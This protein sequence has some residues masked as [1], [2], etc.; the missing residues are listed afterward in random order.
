V[1]FGLALIALL[2][3]GSGQ[4]AAQREGPRLDVSVNAVAAL[5]EGPLVTS[6]N[7]LA[8]ANTLDLLKNGLFPARIHY[9]I[10]LWKKGGWLG[11]DPA[12]RSE[13]DVIVRYDPSTRLYAAV[14]RFSDNSCEN[15][16]GYPT[17]VAAEEQ[18][19]KP[20]RPPLHPSRAGRYYYNLVV[21]VQT[22]TESDLDALNHFLRGPE[23]PV[24]KNPVTALRRGIGQLLSRVLGGDK[25]EFEAQSGVFS[26]P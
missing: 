24:K 3:L 9:R 8:D 19:G 13:W 14:R 7:L 25:R 23:A 21:D 11:D 10:E 6:A 5:Q 2:C 1:R 22:L 20:Y 16:G 18:F 4:L 12:G 15:F 17:V 26:V